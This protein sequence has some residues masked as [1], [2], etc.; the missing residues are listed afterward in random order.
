MYSK[1]RIFIFCFN[2]GISCQTQN[3][4]DG[5]RIKEQACALSALI[6]ENKKI[7]QRSLKGAQA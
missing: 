3:P 2:P 7:S 5:G 6:S 1:I 4:L